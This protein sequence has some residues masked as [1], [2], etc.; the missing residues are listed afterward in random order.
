MKKQSIQETLATLI[1]F[2]DDVNAKAIQLPNDYTA[3]TA[4]QAQ[5]WETI[6]EQCFELEN[7]ASA[8]YMNAKSL[9]TLI[10]DESKGGAL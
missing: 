2:C 8:I 6:Q 5:L 4:D 7:L 3:Q 9:N 1:A 10:G